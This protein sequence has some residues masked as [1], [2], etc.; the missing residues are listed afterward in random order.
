MPKGVAFVK[1]GSNKD[2]FCRDE[3]SKTR[4]VTGMVWQSNSLFLRKNQLKTMEHNGST[5]SRSVVLIGSSGGGMAALGDSSTSSF[6]ESIENELSK[7]RGG[8]HLHEVIFVSLPNGRGMD[9]AKETDNASLFHLT[10]GQQ[11]VTKATLKDINKKVVDLDESIANDIELKKIHGIISVSCKPSLFHQTLEAAGELGIPL[12]GTG[13]T[14]LSIIASNYSV[15]LWGNAG[16]SVATTPLTKAISFSAALARGWGLTYHPWF[17]SSSSRNGVKLR[18]VLNSCLPAFWAVTLAKRAISD[19]DFY[20][21][22]LQSHVLPVTCAVVTAHTRRKSPGVLIAATIAGLAC[23][24]TILGGLLAGWLVALLEE[25]FLYFCILY[26]NIPATMSN[27]LTSGLVGVTVAM[28]ILPFIPHLAEASS[29]FRRVVI[30][31]FEETA[32]N[33]VS[34][35]IQILSKSMLGAMCCYGSKI[36]WYHSIVLPAIL[37][38]M[39][40]GDASILGAIDQLSL[41]LVSAGICAG[42]LFASFF[43]VANKCDAAL[44]WRGLAINLLCGDF[45]EACY[46]LM[47]DNPIVRF[48][49]Y[50]ASSCS[51]GLLSANCRSSAYLPMPFT[52]WLTN[53]VRLMSFASA[54]AFGI[55]FVFAFVGCLVKR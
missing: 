37:L 10:G 25:K 49:G 3:G 42:T 5:I 31:A 45:I 40:V 14:S 2:F 53:D 36:G 21:D 19:H 23:R 20:L 13:G 4:E 12:T 7:I 29:L 26:G 41:V 17:A 32:G 47:D 28:G 52:I 51:V 30:V 24:R 48:G 54:V 27:L 46:P 18:S 38:E 6:V 43:V 15:T 33:E 44:L 16:G 22:M 34:E 35:I 11:T 8:V 9:S 55:S 39:E 1:K 50:I